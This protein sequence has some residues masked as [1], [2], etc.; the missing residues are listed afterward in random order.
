MRFYTEEEIKELTKFFNEE[1]IKDECFAKLEFTSPLSEDDMRT[2]KTMK[3]S[4]FKEK[5]KLNIGDDTY[6]LHMDT[7]LSGITGINPEIADHNTYN[8][9]DL[10][11]PLIILGVSHF[12]DEK[13]VDMVHY[14]E[15]Q[16]TI[17]HYNDEDLEVIVIDKM[18]RPFDKNLL[19]KVADYYGIDSYDFSVYE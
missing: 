6:A 13:H 4:E 16:Y 15:Y 3:F 18:E 7:V 11:Y 19:D 1:Y 8:T 2:K 12:K 17:E 9:D 14:L 5:Y 10:R